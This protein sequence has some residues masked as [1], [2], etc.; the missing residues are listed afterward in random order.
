MNKTT[1][2]TIAFVLGLILVIGFAVTSVFIPKPTPYQYWVFRVLIALGIGLIIDSIAFK[3]SVKMVHIGISAAGSAAIM[4]VFFFLNP[5]LLPTNAITKETI[6]G[7]IEFQHNNQNKTYT[8]SIVGKDIIAGVTTSEI[9]SKGN[10]SIPI[11]YF[12]DKIDSQVECFI[13]SKEKVIFSQNAKLEI[14]IKNF[15][16]IKIDS[17]KNE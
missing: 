4:F 9:D 14:M 1:K 16:E 12:S 2:S 5:P 13:S 17:V 7:H 6:S 11:E 10:F 3:G 8:I 15:Q